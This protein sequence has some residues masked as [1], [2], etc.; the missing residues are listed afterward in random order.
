MIP[1]RISLKGFLCYRDEQII[2]FDAADLWVFTGRNGSGKSAV[3]D[4]MTYAFFN[5]HRGGKQNAAS[6]IHTASDGLCVIFDFDLGGVTYQI[7]RS[8]TRGGRA[9]RQLFRHDDEN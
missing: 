5:A 3:F 9:E 7:R 8:L 1:R 6:L 4:G 2:D